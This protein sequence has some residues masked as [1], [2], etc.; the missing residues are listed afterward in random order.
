MRYLP[1]SRRAVL[2]A[3][4]LLLAL[5]LGGVTLWHGGGFIARA[6]PNSTL[7][8]C[9]VDRDVPYYGGAAPVVARPAPPPAAPNPAIPA[10]PS[11]HYI[12]P[13]SPL[14]HPCQLQLLDQTVTP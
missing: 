10:K 11:D 5:A 9:L 12:P 1:T 7:T 8:A 6:A 3:G 14:E 4:A 13:R 2:L